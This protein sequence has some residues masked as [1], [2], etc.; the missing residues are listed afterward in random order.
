M[1]NLA[2]KENEWRK[3]ITGKD[4]KLAD[5]SEQIEELNREN[6]FLSQMLEKEKSCLD[7]LEKETES[8]KVMKSKL[9]KENSN[10]GFR[11]ST[12][13]LEMRKYATTPTEKQIKEEKVYKRM[14]EMMQTTIK[15]KARNSESSESLELKVFEENFEE[16]KEY[17]NEP[18][19]AS[20]DNLL[21]SPSKMR[22]LEKKR[23]QILKRKVVVKEE[24]GFVFVRVESFSML[25]N[26]VRLVERFW[27]QIEGRSRVR[28][29]GYLKFLR[30]R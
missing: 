9:S 7:E 28:F 6:E 8:L 3:L 4:L 26:E 21:D 11:L 17:M 14:S 20:L 29:K 2:T 10:L 12:L 22:G 16:D 18:N 15:S 1:N 13:E 25:K 30:R 23:T 27:F 24:K 5:F 19:G